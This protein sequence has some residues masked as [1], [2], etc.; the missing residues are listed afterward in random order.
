MNQD[1]E[2][3]QQIQANDAGIAMSELNDT[4]RKLRLE[5]HTLRFKESQEERFVWWILNV[6]ARNVSDLLQIIKDGVPSN[7][8]IEFSRITDRLSEYTEHIYDGTYLDTEISVVVNEQSKTDVSVTVNVLMDIKTDVLNILHD[9]I[10]GTNERYLY[11]HPTN[12]HKYTKWA[13]VDQ[14]ISAAF[15]KAE[16]K[17]TSDHHRSR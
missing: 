5:L 7:R 1:E 17:V 14:D 6:Y 11:E 4:N 15:E 3:K 10:S 16:L 12:S 9:A 8:Q 2:F 13:I